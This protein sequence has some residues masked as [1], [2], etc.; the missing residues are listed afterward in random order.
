MFYGQ[1][2]AI[3]LVFT[4]KSITRFE[5]ISKEPSFAEYYLIGSLYSIICVLVIYGVIM[6]DIIFM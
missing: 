4:A 1:Y 6:K 2:N 3:G 5:R